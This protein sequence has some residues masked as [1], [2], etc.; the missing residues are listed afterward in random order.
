MKCPK[1]SYNQPYRSGMVCGQCKYRFVVD[2]KKDGYTD[3]KFAMALRQVSK[4]GT[5][6]FTFHQFFA[7]LFAHR[8]HLS[9]GLLAVI[10]AAIAGGVVYQFS[11]SP[12]IAAV[13]AIGAGGVGMFGRKLFPPI[14][15]PE[16]KIKGLWNQWLPTAEKHINPFFLTQPTLQTPPDAAPEKDIYDYGVEGILIVDQDIYVDLLVKNKLH[17]EFRLL[18]IAQSA[19]PSYLH[20]QANRLL[21]ERS[22]L[23]V[24][25]LHNGATIVTSMT[26]KFDIKEHK[27]LDLGLSEQDF[28]NHNRLKPFQDVAQKPLDLLSTGQIRRILQ[29]ATQP[30]D[31]DTDGGG[32]VIIDDAPARDTM[33]PTIVIFAGLDDALN[34]DDDGGGDDFG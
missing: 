25:L 26:A 30:A 4:N 20:E 28:L 7:A 23:P 29:R 33:I 10:L 9:S 17:A 2:P 27:I 3:G 24:Y 21:A 6:Y 34:G 32:P 14:A 15:P 11:E 12:F 31:F 22:D 19:Y 8:K 18:I 5:Q 1:C 13:F 16:N